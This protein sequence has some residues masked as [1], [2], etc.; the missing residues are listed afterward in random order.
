MGDKLL[1]FPESLMMA[2][3]KGAL[4][5]ED[6]LPMMEKREKKRNFLPRGVTWDNIIGLCNAQRVP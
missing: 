6:R 5:K 1:P 2:L 4:I 3:D